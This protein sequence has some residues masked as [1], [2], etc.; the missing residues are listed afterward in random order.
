MV[1]VLEQRFGQAHLAS[2]RRRE[3][4][5]RRQG[6]GESLQTFSSEVLR[7]SQEAY[8]EATIAS[9]EQAELDTFVDGIFDWEVQSKVRISR[10]RTI[11]EALSFVLKVE[12]AR[13]ASPGLGLQQ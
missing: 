13:K 1:K 9:I 10:C 5:Y 12:A 7:L 2:I 4:R 8:S 6:R 11:K 3:L